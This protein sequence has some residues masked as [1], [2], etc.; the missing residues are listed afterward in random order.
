MQNKQ[1]PEPWLSFFKDIDEIIE[2]E[3]RV[4]ILGGFAVA[5][6]YGAKRTTS[7]VDTVVISPK[8]NSPNLMKFAGE[9]SKLHNKHKVYIDLV[10]I[11]TLPENYTERLTAVFQ[12]QF[13][14]LRLFVL[15][16]YDVAL[17]KIERNIQRDR[18]DVKYLAKTVPFDAEVLKQRYFN[19]LRVYLGNPIR[20]DLTLKLWLDMIEEDRKS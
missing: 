7:D 1:L 16:A 5:T 12:N 18:D 17:A 4:E 2:S 13:K 3:T 11:V 15:D 8:S 19:E 20:E 14:H 9:G 10:G 6:V